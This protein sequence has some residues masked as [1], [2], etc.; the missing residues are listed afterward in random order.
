M[1][2]SKTDCT[3]G[4]LSRGSLRNSR[5]TSPAVTGFTAST[6]DTPAGVSSL[7]TILGEL[8]ADS[9]HVLDAAYLTG[10]RLGGLADRKPAGDQRPDR[11]RPAL[12]ERAQVGNGVGEA[13]VTGV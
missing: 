1:S 10:Q 4:C 2:C 12:R 5:T 11:A 7:R 6:V 13:L 9:D 8:R 3:P